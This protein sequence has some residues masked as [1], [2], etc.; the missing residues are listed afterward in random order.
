MEQTKQTKQIK[1]Q[2]IKRIIKLI[3]YHENANTVEEAFVEYMKEPFEINN[4]LKS[5]E[6]IHDLI[7]DGYSEF[8]IDEPIVSLSRRFICPYKDED[9]KVK[10]DV[11]FEKYITDPEIYAS[12]HT[13][14]FKQILN[15]E[16]LKER[17][18]ECTEKNLHDVLTK[19][20]NKITIKF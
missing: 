20:K 16:K 2:L 6:D 7:T 13:E 10:S 5:D 17:L 19:N 1:E 9:S 3:E 12:K 11:E 18:L 15:N 8:M 14:H 4:D